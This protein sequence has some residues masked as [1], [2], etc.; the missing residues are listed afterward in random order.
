MENNKTISFA[1]DAALSALADELDGL[2]EEYKRNAIL[3]LQR[4]VQFWAIRY[5]KLPRVCR[6][7]CLYQFNKYARRYNALVSSLYPA[8]AGTPTP[9]EEILS[10]A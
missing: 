10:I 9:I 3:Q 1:D 5:S 4:E 8:Y 7:Y 6:P 2:A